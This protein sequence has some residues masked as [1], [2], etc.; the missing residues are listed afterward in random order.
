MLQKIPS[1]LEHSLKQSTQHYPALP[2]NSKH[3]SPYVTE[4]FEA[5]LV[6]E[7][8]VRDRLGGMT[9]DMF[10]NLPIHKLK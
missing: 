8:E 3:P 6:F 1:M 10:D 2:S 7:Q 5:K 9:S 4:D